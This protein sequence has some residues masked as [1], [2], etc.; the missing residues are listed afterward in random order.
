MKS[1]QVSSVP[2]KPIDPATG[3]PGR[4]PA[5]TPV[6]PKPEPP[7]Q[8][9]LNPPKTTPARRKRRSTPGESR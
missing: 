8:P 1:L 5:P 2:P 7:A 6:T 4:S 9:P 3:N